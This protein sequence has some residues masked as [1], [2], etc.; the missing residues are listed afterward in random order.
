MTVRTRFTAAEV[1]R[2]VET[3]PR[4]HAVVREISSKTGVREE[5]VRK[6]LGESVLE[7]LDTLGGIYSREVGE[8]IARAERLRDEVHGFYERIFTGQDRNPDPAT[9]V[10]AFE[11][12]HQAIN[13]M[14]D[15]QTWAKRRSEAHGGPTIPPADIPAVAPPVETAPTSATPTSAAGGG[16]GRGGGRGGGTP[17]RVPT[18]AERHAA[19]TR[20]LA[21][22]ES[23]ALAAARASHP[24]LVDAALR[25][26]PGA[27]SALAEALRVAGVQ[28]G[29]VE[30][31][32]A[33]V[34]AVHEPGLS[35]ALGGRS[36]GSPLGGGD[37]RAVAAHE[38]FETLSPD[39]KAVVERAAEADPEFVR[40]TVRSE[41]T[42][43]EPRGAKTPWQPRAMDEFCAAHGLTG[44]DRANLEAALRT[45][46]DATKP[47]VTARRDPA[48]PIPRSEWSRSAQRRQVTDIDPVVGLGLPPVGDV[49][50][51]LRASG[52]MRRL[53]SENP[54][55]FRA[56]ADGWLALVARR[57]AEGK[58]P[59]SLRNYVLRL[60]RTQIRGML[61][62]YSA[63]FRLGEDFWVLKAPGH[64]VTTPGTDFVVVAKATGEIWF[65]DNK[66]L[67][68]NSL[69]RVSSLVD[70]LAKNIADDV[71]EFG[72]AIEQ[73]TLP[74]PPQVTTAVGR[75]LEA[76]AEIDV[77]TR[78]R[79]PEEI[80]SPEI[81]GQIKAICDRHG[82]RR[83][84]TNAGG[85]LSQLSTALSQL[86]VDLANLE[87]KEIVLPQRT[88]G[89]PS[90]GT[91]P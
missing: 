16:S 20:A 85:E 57:V 33:A 74:V 15:P 1:A 44:A 69:G 18:T 19:R 84:V 7:S 38:A 21:P 29:E 51:A 77:V 86:G 45:M 83:V 30:A 2:A 26:E 71:L 31:A 5:L 59:P 53:A 52:T 55:H 3:H 58:Q 9:L 80:R 47:E 65:C 78:G 48:S 24:A 63:A 43:G 67:S 76:A 23:Q 4:M 32:L 25:G 22:I 11:D 28:P 73:E 10:R 64:D 46:F 35:Y 14:A 87:G 6:H 41:I 89:E 90:G 72:P 82:V 61:G 62:E 13:D 39:E 91:I 88:L 79:T 49:A 60:M 27:A 68:D 17:P 37:N 81:Q 36:G 75:S 12:L 70:N 42:Y 54:Q 40:R 50:D 66:A 8:A 56:L 34:A